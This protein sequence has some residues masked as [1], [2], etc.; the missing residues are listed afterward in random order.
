MIK[1]S[2]EVENNNIEY[3]R[4]IKNDDIDNLNKLGS[5]ILRRI[6]SDNDDG[7]CTG[8]AI[9]YIGINDDGSMGDCTNDQYTK[10]IEL[11]DKVCEIVGCVKNEISHKIYGEYHVGEFLIRERKCSM[12]ME[13]VVLMGGSVDAGKSSVL[14]CLISGEPDDGRGKSRLKVFS[15]KDE[16]KTGRTMSISHH[17]LGIDCAGNPIYD[18]NYQWSDI[19]TR[20]KKLIKFMDLA[21][22][23]KYSKTTYKGYI[24]VKTGISLIM[25]GGNMG[26]TNSTREHIFLCINLRIPFCFVITK[27]DI[28]ENRKNIL[29]E[30]IDSIKKIMNLPTIRRNLF[31]IID[32]DDVLTCAKNI[33]SLSIV[34]M[35]MVSNI[36]MEGIDK[37]IKFLN[38]V[39]QK[40]IDNIPQHGNTV[41]FYIDSTFQR[42]GFS[43]I[44]GGQLVNGKIKLNQELYIG[45]DS[46][47][48]FKKV[49]IKS[50]H[51][52]RT[53]IDTT[54]NNSYYC[55]SLKGISR[56][57]IR[58]GMVLLTK[59]ICF[60]EFEANV[61]IHHANR[62]SIE[63]TI[64]NRTCT[65]RVGSQVTIHVM[66]IRQN[67]VILEIKDKKSKIEGVE[68]NILTNGDKAIVRFRFLYRPQ[69]LKVGEDILFTEGC[70][71][72]I[73][74]ISKLD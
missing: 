42:K 70:I 51:Y 59:G 12:P 17:I 46:N 68:S 21:G 47:C 25:V 24:L 35:F 65:I 26:I 55:F 34:P 8:E 13:I 57:E 53:N 18:V 40:K 60:R 9:Y 74:K 6:N 56:K 43:C 2:K 39:P 19:V 28:C 10:S 73:G 52:N 37:L 16:I 61:N 15:S 11:L 64:Y 58:K 31:T 62:R 30:T 54:F 71:R 36:S 49:S 48:N 67:A 1:L 50:I 69:Y 32:N 3:K 23:E 14:G 20:S 29:K 33:H 41:E 38:L 66:N 4:L 22:H 45:P 44:V 63:K 27:I 7:Y 72:S 5:Q